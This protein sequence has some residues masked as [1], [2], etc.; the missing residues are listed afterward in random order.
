MTTKAE[1]KTTAMTQRRRLLKVLG[2][3]GILGLAGTGVAPSAP[4]PP[5]LSL[6]EADFYRRHDLAG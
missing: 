2:G 6:R 3:L 5:E 4:R 1:G